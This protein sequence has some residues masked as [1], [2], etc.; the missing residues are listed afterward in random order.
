MY[1]LTGIL[2]I[3]MAIAPF[4]LGYT[5]NTIAMWTSIVLG[6]VVTV[7]SIFGWV[8]RTHAKWGWG[9]VA[10]AGILAVIAPFYFGFTGLTMALWTLVVLGVWVVILAEYA[11]FY[12]EASV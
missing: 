9:T 6:V 2:G 12:A 7:A 11:V 10:L 1:W 4:V 3:A 8:D 5:H